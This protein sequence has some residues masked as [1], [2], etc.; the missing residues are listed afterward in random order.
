VDYRRIETTE[1]DHMSAAEI[2]IQS[3]Q[4]RISEDRSVKI[5][6]MELSFYF[7]PSPD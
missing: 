6:K 3:E 2:A 7:Q 1:D 5:E 4:Q